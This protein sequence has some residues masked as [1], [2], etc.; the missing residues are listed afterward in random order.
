MPVWTPKQKDGKF[1]NIVNIG[2]YYVAVFLLGIPLYII[3]FPAF[4][5]GLLIRLLA[6]LFKIKLD[7]R[8]DT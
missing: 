3:L 5:V 2:V 6:R 8:F 1:L 7:E 4:M